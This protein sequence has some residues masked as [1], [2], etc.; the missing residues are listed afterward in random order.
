MSLLPELSDSQYTYIQIVAMFC[1]GVGALLVFSLAIWVWR[2][3]SA[4][5]RD[6]LAR[7]LSTV[8]VVGL[9]FV[10]ILIYFLLRPRETMAERYERKLIEEI[11]TREVSANAIGRK[12]ARPATG[13]AGAPPTT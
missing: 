12:S 3:I 8:L 11:L 4:R 13:R 5:S 6:G 2:D 9:P 10:G 7:V 1:G